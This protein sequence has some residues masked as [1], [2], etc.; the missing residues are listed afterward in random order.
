M[1]ISI[2][3][4]VYQGASTIGNLVEEL[5]NKLP[6]RNLEI[7]LVNDGSRDKSNEVC[8]DI[9]N[10]HK[11]AVKY[12]NLAKNFGEHNAV[13]AGLNY[14]Q[15]DYAVIIDD[16]FQNPPQEI[17]KLVDKAMDENYDVVY[18]YYDKK[19][20][21]LFRNFGSKFNDAVASYLLDKPK[22][23]Y[24]SSFKCISRFLI[25]EIIKYKGPY[26]YIDGL[27]LRATENIG[28]VLVRHEKRQ[29]GKSGYTLRKLIRLWLN[30]FVNFS[31][32]PLR[33]SIILGFIFSLLGGIAAVYSTIDKIIH[34]DIPHGFTSIIVAILVFSGIQLIMLGLI[35]EYI[36]KQ[37]MA[38]NQTPQYVVRQIL[39]EEKKDEEQ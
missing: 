27:I 33:V 37:F 35:G 32:Y 23:L 22:G 39:P 8:I 31:I 29:E 38:S 4:P 2:I 3:I 17:E 16:D 12:I 25:K 34:P 30:M 24:L 14:A 10:K 36:G 1:K 28:K 7:I 20:H 18:S 15:G 11:S 26:P 13:L 9:F 19:Q 21:S 6:Y 5:V